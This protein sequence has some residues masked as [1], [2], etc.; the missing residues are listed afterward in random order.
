MVATWLLALAVIA[1]AV[2]LVLL[3][4]TKRLGIR[5]IPAYLVGLVLAYGAAT[6]LGMFGTYSMG[7]ISGNEIAGIVVFISAGVIA[8]GPLLAWAA[9]G[10]AVAVGK[11]RERDRRDE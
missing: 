10:I 11:C 1:F 8:V 2:Q 9:Y 4:K 3:R 5:L 6:F 7:A